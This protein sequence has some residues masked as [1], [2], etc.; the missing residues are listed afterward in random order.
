MQRRPL[1]SKD[2]RD[3]GL[4]KNAFLPDEAPLTLLPD[5]YYRPWELVAQNLTALVRDGGFRDAVHELPILSTDHLKSAAEWRRAYVLLAYFTNAYVWGGREAAEILP[6]QIS[7]PFLRVSTE[8]ELPPVLTASAANAWN[9]TCSGAQASDPDSLDA[10]VSFTG[11]ES[12]SWF[13]LVGT[14]IEAKGAGMVKVALAT[15]D[16]M[17]TNNYPALI[18]ALKSVRSFILDTTALLSRQYEKCDPMVFYHQIR[19]YYAGSKNMEAAGL[20]RGIFYDEGDGRGQWRQLQGGSMGQSP[21]IH[22]FD[23]I[24]GIDHDEHRNG[25]QRGFHS[26][27]RKY[28]QGPHRR[29]LEHVCSAGQVRHL[30]LGPAVSMSEEHRRLRESYTAA[31]EAL[32][33]LRKKHLQIVTRYIVLPSKRQWNEASPATGL[34]NSTGDG[35]ELTGTAGT[36]LTSFLK[37]V[38]DETLAA[39]RLEEGARSGF[40]AIRM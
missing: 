5:S 10:L 4:S 14:A 2:L 27:S 3:F 36:M 33:D 8:L 18:D 15:L 19:P 11:T 34:A 1:S 35:E 13:L 17:D 30:A 28:M 32:A 37:R 24:L 20:P 16:A 25:S 21:L 22:L 31:A 40:L 12:E 29:F 39:G 6:P 9:F 26:E 38:R 23:A 7:V